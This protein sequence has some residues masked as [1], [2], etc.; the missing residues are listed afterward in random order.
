MTVNASNS[1]PR[2]RGERAL[3]SGRR[4]PP[5]EGGAEPAAQGLRSGKSSLPKAGTGSAAPR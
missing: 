1:I 5:Q 3:H 4:I 2:D